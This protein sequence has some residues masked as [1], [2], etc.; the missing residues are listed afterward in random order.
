MSDSNANPT[1][2]TRTALHELADQGVSVWLDDLN[3]PM[4]ADGDLAA[5]IDRGVL[6]ITTNPTIF[7]TALSEGEA[8][9]DQIESLGMDTVS[10]DEAV[11]ALTTTDVRDACDVFAP[12]FQRTGGLDGRVS[13]EVDP[14]LSADTAATVETAK[15]LWA[16]IDRPNLFI[17]IPATVEGLP[18]ITQTLAEGI[19][20]NVTL[21]F[22]LD[23][24]RGVMN[25]YLT[26]LEQA[27]ERGRDL[28]SIRSV[29]SFF[30]SRVDSEVDKRLDQIGTDEALALR[31][32][33]GVAN[34]RLAY[35]AFEE[36]FSTPRW[37]NL[38]DD[39]AHVQRPLWAST[40]VKNPDYPDTLYVTELVAPDTVN[41]MPDKTL[42]ATI[43]HAEIT[44]DTVTGA[45]DDAQKVLDD[46][47]AVGVS[48]SDVV[49]LLEEEGVDKFEKSW[50][51]LLDTVAA[52]MSKHPGRA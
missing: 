35:Q 15:R 27:R 8:Y 52:E 17:K 30:V 36:V 29:A 10:T 9:T 41:T 13:I 51:E 23:R 3:R 50:Q 39:G 43:D 22:S 20:V 49:D 47:A 12:V 25:A 5:Y 19:S 33:A 45:Y 37:Q 42:E 2:T 40:G 34:A 14:R 31:G 6:G 44:G 38:A 28:S 4:I 32:K 48:Y 26:G 21:I 7:A 24:Y 1:T 11:F 46:L 18:A 16:E